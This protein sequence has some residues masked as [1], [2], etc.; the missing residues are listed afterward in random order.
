MMEAA[1]SFAYLNEEFDQSSLKPT[2]SESNNENSRK[3][4]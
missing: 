1:E 4:S 3:L 2:N